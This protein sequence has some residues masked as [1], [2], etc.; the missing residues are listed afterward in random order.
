MS[1]ITTSTCRSRSNARC[2]A[3]VSA[4]R[5]AVIRST[6]GS[7]A[8]LRTS[9]RSAAD[10]RLS[11]RSRMA[12]A[13]AFVTPMAATTTAN[14]SSRTVACAAIWAASSRC[15]RPPTEKI[16]SFCPR[17]SVASPSTTETPVM[18]G[19]PGVARSAGL[20]TRPPIGRSSE[21]KTGG[22]PSSGWPRPSHTLPSHASPTGTRIGPPPNET[23]TLSRA[24]PVVPSKTC[25]TASSPLASRT[26]PWRVSPESR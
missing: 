15:G 25:T 5:G 20:I 2:S 26:T 22:P 4:T 7:S 23:R 3:T 14:G 12:D 13:S 21:P 10:S 8:V 19:S 1:A 16:G 11:S 24:S 18:I 6:R 9:T 17:T